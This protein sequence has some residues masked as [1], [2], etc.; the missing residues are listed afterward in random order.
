MY[1]GWYYRYQSMLVGLGDGSN[2]NE[3]IVYLAVVTTTA[4]IGIVGG[5]AIGI[6]VM[7]S[8]LL[9]GRAHRFVL[10]VFGIRYRQ[11]IVILIIVIVVVILVGLRIDS[12][13]VTLEGLVGLVKGVV[14][15]RPWSVY[16]AGLWDRVCSVSVHGDIGI[17]SGYLEEVR[18]VEL[19][20]GVADIVKSEGK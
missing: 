18:Y 16:Q 7:T 2:R 3:R 6:M 9:K 8:G 14:V 12:R 17:E 10:V 5:M 20:I 19:C 4:G 1:E 11:V 13:E 15:D